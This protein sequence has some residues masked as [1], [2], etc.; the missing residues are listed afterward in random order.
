[1]GEC[2]PLLT[3]FTPNRENRKQ[4]SIVLAPKST[5][6]LWLIR[7]RQMNLFAVLSSKRPQSAK[8]WPSPRWPGR[9]NPFKGPRRRNGEEE[10]GG[11]GSRN[12]LL[13]ENTQL[14]DSA[15]R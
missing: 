8:F 13:V 4:K 6:V 5:S 12:I 9:E 14:I 3:I 7:W 2:I 11:G 1:P 10:G 15:S